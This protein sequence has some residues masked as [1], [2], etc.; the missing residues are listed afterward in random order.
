MVEKLIR[1]NQVAVLV[2]RG[3]GAGWSTWN[4]ENPQIQEAM[5]FDP[6]IAQAVL[7]KNLDKAEE[8]AT[9]KYPGDSYTGGIE[10]NMVVE[11]VNIGD[12]FYIQEY[13]GSE[14]LKILGPDYGYVA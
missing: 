8:I 7:D 6:D 14:S 4:T 1:G 3:Y 9:R 11:W 2:S 10:D 12:R 5:L 13:D